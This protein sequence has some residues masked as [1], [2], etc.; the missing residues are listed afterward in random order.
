MMG[1]LMTHR[2]E[3]R[4]FYIQI[5]RQQKQRELPGL[6]WVSETPKPTQWHTFSKQDHAYSKVATPLNLSW[7]LWLQKQE[8]PD[9][10]DHNCLISQDSLSCLNKQFQ[11]E[12]TIATCMYLHHS[13][14]FFTRKPITC[15]YKRFQ[16]ALTSH[17]PT[18]RQTFHSL[19]REACPCCVR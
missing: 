11:K 10:W 1:N 7:I 16:P 17:F 3:S 8:K 5:Q 12:G 9:F 4:E 14:Y 6:G 13:S 19:R 18:S 2:V 15:P